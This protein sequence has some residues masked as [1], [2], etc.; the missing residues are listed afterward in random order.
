MKSP[1]DLFKSQ[2]LCWLVDS[3]LKIISIYDG[4]F[5]KGL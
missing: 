2:E 5:I 1:N 4:A 3:A